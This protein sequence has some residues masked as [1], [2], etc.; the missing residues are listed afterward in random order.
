MC[1]HGPCLINE[2]AGITAGVCG[3]DVDAMAI[4]KFLLQNAMGAV[5]AKLT[6]GVFVC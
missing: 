3:I 1:S 4:R 2:S 6:E 5:L